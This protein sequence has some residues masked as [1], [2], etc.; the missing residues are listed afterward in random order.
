MSEWWVTKVVKS[1]IFDT[2][3]S[4]DIK[5]TQSTKLPTHVW[6]PSAHGFQF[7]IPGHQCS[8]GTTSRLKRWCVW[9]QT[10]NR[11]FMGI[12][13]VKNTIQAQLGWT[14]L[15]STFHW[16]MMAPVILELVAFKLWPRLINRRVRV[17]VKYARKGAETIISCICWMQIS[18]S[19]DAPQLTHQQQ[20]VKLNRDFP[21]TNVR[22]LAPGGLP[23]CGQSFA[24]K[25]K[26]ERSLWVGFFEHPKTIWYL[27]SCHSQMNHHEKFMYGE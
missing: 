18:R 3:D 4:L 20:K 14:T 26:V 17:I 22:L 24:A 27:A 25:L 5:K 2:L 1:S 12:H 19:R 13:W 21:T 15:S 9:N 11:Q 16:G 23:F 10:L 7:D 6:A 8:L